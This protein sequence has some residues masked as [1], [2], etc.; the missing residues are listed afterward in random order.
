MYKIYY[1]MIQK[2]I[3]GLLLRG[4]DCVTTNN[5]YLYDFYGLDSSSS[6]RRK[7]EKCTI[8]FFN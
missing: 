8:L 2:S 1:P 4:K 7:R 3:N 5:T 6:R